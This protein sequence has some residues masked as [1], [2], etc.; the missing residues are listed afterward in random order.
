MT[1]PVRSIAEVRLT[2]RRLELL[3]RDNPRVIPQQSV[4]MFS[5][6]ADIETFVEGKEVASGP[7]FLRRIDIALSERATS[8]RDLD[9][10]GVTAAALFPGIEGACRTL[11][12]KWF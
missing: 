10:M 6:L 4:H 9:V 11:V 5:N 2:F 7:R 1:E 12:E 3:A 8:M